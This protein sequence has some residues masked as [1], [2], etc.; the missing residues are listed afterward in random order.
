[1]LHDR[2]SDHIYLGDVEEK[3]SLKLRKLL[4][5]GSDANELRAF[6]VMKR[7]YK[8]CVNHEILEKL[9]GKILLEVITELG[10]WPLLTNKD[11][12]ESDFDWKKLN[13]KIFEAG[14]TKGFLINVILEGDNRDPSKH[15]IEI[16]PLAQHYIADYFLEGLENE[17][18]MAYHEFMVDYATL[19]GAE[20]NSTKQQM[21]DV[22]NFETQL[23]KVSQF[24]DL[25]SP[26]ICEIFFS[27]LFLMT[28]KSEF[29]SQS[30][31]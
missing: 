17:N 28:T 20:I 23:H 11:F 27:S 18:V 22:I 4:E 14:F 31:R 13:N 2:F 7:F 29:T 9:N 6:K 21:L 30:M 26:V 19:L 15:I 5:S 8:T 12:N 1:M 24:N 10:G 16:E 3:E 25:T